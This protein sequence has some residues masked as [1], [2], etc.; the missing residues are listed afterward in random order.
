MYDIEKKSERARSD[1]LAERFRQHEKWGVQ[2]H[3]YAYYGHILGEEMGEVSKE[4]IEMGNSRADLK[5]LRGE[6]VHV[7]AVAVAII[8]QIDEALYPEEGK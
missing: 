7:A 3:T 4:I 6:L 2:R 1:I 5:K 8:E